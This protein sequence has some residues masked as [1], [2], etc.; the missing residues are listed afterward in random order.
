ME[1]LKSALNMVKKGVY[2]AKIDLKDA[3]YCIAVAE[4][5]RKFLRFTWGESVYQY[6]CLPNG[7]A[8]ALRIFTKVLKPHFSSLR[9]LGHENIHR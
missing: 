8:S 6:T 7:L 4:S 5:D 3:Y 9:K 1:T 2:F